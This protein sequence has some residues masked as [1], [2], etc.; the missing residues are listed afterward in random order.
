[1]MKDRD[2]VIEKFGWRLRF[3]IGSTSQIWKR[4]WKWRFEGVRGSNYGITLRLRGE[5]CIGIQ[6]RTRF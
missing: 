3:Y 1:M 6:L 2:L 5:Q 4:L